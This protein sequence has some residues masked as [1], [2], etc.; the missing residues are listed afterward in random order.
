MKTQTE[1]MLE[2][3][4][5]A[6]PLRVHSLTGGCVATVYRA[7]MPDGSRVVAKIDTGPSANLS[8]EGEMLRYLRQSTDFPV[9]EVLHATEELL[10]MEYIDNDGSSSTAGEKRAAELLA[11]LHSHGSDTFGFPYDTL[12]GP[13]PQPNPKTT[14]WVDF[15][16]EDRLM[17][18]GTLCVNAGQMEPKTL[19][20]LDHLCHRLDDYLE[21]G[22]PSLIHGDLWGGNV[23]YRRGQL[24][25]FID[26][27]IYFA[28]PEIELAFTTLFTTFGEPFYTRYDELRPIREGFFEVRKDL[29]N[30]YPLL[31]H[32]RLFGGSYLDAVHAILRRF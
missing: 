7:D 4:L 9:P 15:F 20:M 6:R 13:L 12:I 8:I 19:A 11:N 31:V 28:D 21:P 22:P 27:A 30:L 14:S 26:P 5:G 29:Y 32:V 18:M 23:L 1:T 24:A 25:A 10:V 2:S 3:A 17:Y 16:A